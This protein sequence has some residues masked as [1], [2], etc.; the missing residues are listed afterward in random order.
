MFARFLL[1]LAP[2]PLMGQVK[3]HDPLVS[4]MA[5]PYGIERRITLK[6]IDKVHFGPEGGGRLELTLENS[7]VKRVTLRRPSFQLECAGADG[8]Y[9]VLADLECEEIVFPVTEED[10]TV[11]RRHVVKMSPRVASDRLVK[12]L[13]EAAKAQRPVRLI[14]RADM[15]VKMDEEDDF[16]RRKLK[17]ELRG[18]T[19]LGQGFKP[20]W[21]RRS[22]SLPKCGAR[23]R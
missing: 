15:S 17:L 9:R 7:G 23:D 1:V 3:I 13:R 12:A 14:G 11:R 19:R 10:R 8:R 5:K 6:S 16:N 20:E 21:Y 22:A 4:V 2:L 18:A